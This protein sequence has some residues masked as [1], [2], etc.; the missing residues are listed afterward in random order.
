MDGIKDVGTAIAFAAL[1]LL[2]GSA[3][4]MAAVLIQDWISGRLGERDES[5]L[6]AD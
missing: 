5:D 1:V 2:G 3:V 6:E 4:L